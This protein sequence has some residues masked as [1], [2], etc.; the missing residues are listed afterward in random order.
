MTEKSIETILE[1][2]T[3][4]LMSL[5]GVVGV[6]EGRYNGVP[7]IK[8]MVTTKTPELIERVGQAVEGYAVEIVET[9]EIRV[10]DSD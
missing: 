7:C 3:P 8:V 5:P 4:W 6:G 10:L 9:G 1:A 2:H